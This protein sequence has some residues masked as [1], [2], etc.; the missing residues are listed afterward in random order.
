VSGTVDAVEEMPVFRYSNFVSSRND[1]IVVI[2]S[3][4][5]LCQKKIHRC[6]VS[7][8]KGED[9]GQYKRKLG[10]LR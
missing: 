10:L 7:L 6:K 8:E 2:N 3:L 4:S 5:L 9:S 1:R